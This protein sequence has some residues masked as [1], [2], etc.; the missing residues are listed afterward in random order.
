MN[1]DNLKKARESMHFT[2]AQAAEKLSISDG[3][4]KNYEQGKREPNNVLLCKIADLFG[5]TTDYLLG[6]DSGEPDALDQ[7]V[8]EFNM[9]ALERKIVENYFSLPESMRGDLMKF[10]QK[11]VKEVDSEND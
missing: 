8:S 3:A 11:T 10:L 1:I 7:L 9:S 5:V 6:R 4:Y 2:Q